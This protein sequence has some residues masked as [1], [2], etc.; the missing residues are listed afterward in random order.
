MST[1]FVFQPDTYF[2][3]TSCG[4]CCRSGFE[5]PVQA[6]KAR[7]IKTSEPYQKLNKAGYQPLEVVSGQVHLLSYNESGACHFHQDDRCA[8]HAAHGLEYKPVICQM[9]PFNFV[10]TPDGVFVST[11]FSCP[12]VLAGLG[13]PVQQQ[14]PDLQALW[15]QHKE[16]VPAFPPIRKHILVTAESTVTWPQ[17][18]ELERL[19]LNAYRDHDPVRFLF[20]SA[21]RL[22]RPDP[23]NTRFKKALK[24]KNELFE[25]LF[26]PFVWQVLCYL[27]EREAH[28]NLD[29]FFECLQLGSPAYSQRL[30]M[31]IPPFEIS[32]PDSQLE[33]LAITRYVLNQWHGKLLLI[34]PSMVSRLV[35][36]AAAMAVVL[37][38]LKVLKEAE[39][40]R[41]FSYDALELAFEVCEEKIVSQSNDL[42][43]LLVEIEEIMLS[44]CPGV[45]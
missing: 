6:D 37:F 16:K 15:N 4:K 3:C 31:E 24:D 1:Q 21:C 29:E 26:E 40:V 33:S 20:N 23:E 43:P 41:H 17:Y 13:E 27:E 30:G 11:L 39:G 38:D 44:E 45:A 5:I 2:T 8:L 9:Y 10:P 12:A 22:V 35:L 34:G 28:P 42:E 18:L 7:L 25:S 36:V 19:F 32:K 14:E